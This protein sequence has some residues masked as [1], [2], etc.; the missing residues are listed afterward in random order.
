SIPE[1]RGD[2][3]IG[4]VEELIRNE[5]LQRPQFFLKRTDG[6][7]GDNPLDAEKFH[8][9]D[10]GPKVDLRGKNA[11]AAPVAREERDTFS[12]KR[13]ENHCVRRIPKRCPNAKLAEVVQS[14]HRIQPAAD[15]VLDL[16]LQTCQF[17]IWI[18]CII[19]M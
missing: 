14:W 6:A 18:F 7:D 11:M 19:C 5:E 3:M 12:F 9:V 16:H 2:A 8:C 10:V 13:A 15:T 4:A 17:A 1:K